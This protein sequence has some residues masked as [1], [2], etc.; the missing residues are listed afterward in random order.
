LEKG[1][2]SDVEYYQQLRDK[3]IYVY[4]LS[5][6][7]AMCPALDVEHFPVK[8][9]LKK[10]E[11][12][13]LWGELQKNDLIK[14]DSDFELTQ[15]YRVTGYPGFDFSTPKY[16]NFHHHFFPSSLGQDYKENYI[17]VNTNF[18]S[19]YGSSLESAL[20]GAPET[21]AQGRDFVK[22]CYEMEKELC[23]F[24]LSR[25]K[26]IISSYPEQK[27]LIRPHPSDLGDQVYIDLFG[28]F[29]N[30]CISRQGSANQVLS[31]AKLLI[32]HDCTTAFQ[33]YLLGLPVISLS[34]PNITNDL[35]AGWNFAFGARSGNV[36]EIKILIDQV[37]KE[38]KFS[39]EIRQNIEKNAEYILQSRYANLGK[40]TQCILETMLNDTK[41]TFEKSL[42]Y[43]LHNSRSIIQKIKCFIR[44]F[45]PLHYK[46]VGV[47]R[48]H[49]Q[50][51][52]ASD[53]LSRL[54]YMD[55][56]DNISTEY[57]VK[58]IFHNT[59]FINVKS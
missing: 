27:F 45:L 34:N 16:K 35:Y 24:F 20:E 32:H 51:F 4:C 18:G 37:L 53:V 44:A 41:V 22:R 3:G 47:D 6:E 52:T 49:L 58:K 9:A 59:Y 56:M 43:K 30:V 10:V 1:I 15:K 21:G 5:D 54:R 19:F 25:L 57:K 33:G 11:K 17:L 38:G 2:I 46:I 26:E 12:I 14:R 50:K 48:L 7:G 40:S 8:E 13:F 36:E 23:P 29:K 42:S 31:R 28:S 55:R 39:A